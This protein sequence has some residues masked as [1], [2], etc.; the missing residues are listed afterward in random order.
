MVNL[1]HNN[2]TRRATL[3]NAILITLEHKLFFLQR[4]LPASTHKPNPTIDNQS[5]YEHYPYT[6]DGVTT[7]SLTSKTQNMTQH[8]GTISINPRYKSHILSNILTKPCQYHATLATIT[9]NHHIKS[10]HLTWHPSR[11][12]PP[13]AR[14]P[15]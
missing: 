6:T 1:N 13:E 8:T 2:P 3:T 12:Y 4:M 7:D 14:A 15:C 5:Q 11:E 9:S 10:P